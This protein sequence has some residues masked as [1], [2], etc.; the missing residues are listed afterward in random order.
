MNAK[1]Q[2]AADGVVNGYEELQRQRALEEAEFRA[3]LAAAPRSVADLARDLLVQLAEASYVRVDAAS[4]C[5]LHRLATG[6]SEDA[7][8]FENAGGQP[9]HVWTG[10]VVESMLGDASTARYRYAY[11]TK[12]QDVVLAAP[13][14]SGKRLSLSWH[15]LERGV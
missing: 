10:D 11:R 13:R 7:L 1:I 15:R 5:A 12:E 8:I 14:Y 6:S 2:Q 4:M 9:F 3:F